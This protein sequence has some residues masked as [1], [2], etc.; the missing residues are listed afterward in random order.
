[1]DIEKMTKIAELCTTHLTAGSNYAQLSDYKSAIQEFTKVIDLLPEYI[2][3]TIEFNKSDAPLE[4]KNINIDNLKNHATLAYTG[5]AMSYLSA[6]EETKAKSDMNMADKIKNKTS[7]EEI[8]SEL[9]GGGAVGCI[10][11]IVIIFLIYMFLR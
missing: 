1:M 10:T 3:L 8:K 4:L 2:N 6:G 9:T 11:I 5:R 7:F